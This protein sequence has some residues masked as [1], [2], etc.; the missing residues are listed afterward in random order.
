MALLLLGVYAG[1]SP[2]AY[3][4][5]EELAG[6]EGFFALAG[7]LRGSLLG[8]FLALMSVSLVVTFFMIGADRR[9]RDPYP[10]TPAQPSAPNPPS[11][12]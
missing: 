11:T 6:P 4:D 7:Q 10:R 8:L 9:T 3:D 2:S 5:A 12:P 1:T